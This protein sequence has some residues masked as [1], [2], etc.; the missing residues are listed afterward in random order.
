MGIASVQKNQHENLPRF[1]IMSSKS[2]LIEIQLDETPP[3]QV[4][5]LEEA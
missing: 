2:E 1:Q 4:N 5:K 3:E